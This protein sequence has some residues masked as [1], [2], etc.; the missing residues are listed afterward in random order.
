MWCRHTACIRL[1][2]TRCCLLLAAPSLAS[3]GAF[4]SSRPNHSCN[5]H[6]AHHDDHEDGARLYNLRGSRG[7]QHSLRNSQKANKPIPTPAAAAPTG[8]DVDEL[9]SPPMGGAMVAKLPVEARP[10]TSSLSKA[11]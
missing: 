4:G 5:R 9:V 11:L 10:T 1:L 2:A 7:A 6:N 3:C 8:K